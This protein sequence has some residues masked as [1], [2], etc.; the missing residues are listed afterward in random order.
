MR[1]HAVLLV[2]LSTLDSAVSMH[3]SQCWTSPHGGG[4]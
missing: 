1:P 4:Q 2:L 3:K